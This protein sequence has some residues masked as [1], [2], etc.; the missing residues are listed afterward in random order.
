MEKV[1]FIF[2][3]TGVGKSKMAIKLAQKYN[4][5]IISSDSVQIYRGF[6]IGSAKITTKE[7]E[8]VKHYNIDICNSADYF[9]VSDFVDI[10][11]KEIEEIFKHGKIPIVVGGTGLYVSALLGGYNFGG[12]NRNEDYRKGLEKEIENYGLYYVYKKLEN[13][14]ANLAK[15]IDKN[16]KVRVIRALEIAKFGKEQTKSSPPYDFKIFALTLPREQLYEKVEARVDIMLQQGLVKEVETL[17]AK[18][19]KKSCQPM[20]AIGYKET[21]KY[22]EGE[23]T[24]SELVD[25]IKKNTRHYAKRQLT[26][27]RGLAKTYNVSE[28]NVEDFVLAQKSIE[29]EIKEWL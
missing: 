16:N 17:L 13:L 28:I 3:S 29:K 26:Y 4:G 12:T 27:L 23:I 6:D 18:G 5:E 22:I 14:D 19:V 11:R 21:V 8:G 20:T 24:L 1:I 2:G 15:K 7:M 9:S 25:E 10:T